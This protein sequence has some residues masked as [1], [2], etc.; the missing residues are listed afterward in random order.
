MF[1]KLIEIEYKKQVKDHLFNNF[2][3]TVP[4]RNKLSRVFVD[5]TYNYDVD[6]QVI[7]AILENVHNIFSNN[8][9]YFVID[10]EGYLSIF[11]ITTICFYK[12]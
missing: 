12:G 10:E 2:H 8:L 1:S 6:T 3:S 7:N 11:T 9:Q 5:V 4:M